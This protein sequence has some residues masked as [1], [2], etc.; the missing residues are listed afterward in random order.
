MFLLK[1]FETFFVYIRI[2]QESLFIQWYL[3]LLLELL[4]RDILRIIYHIDRMNFHKQRKFIAK[5]QRQGIAHLKQFFF[6]LL[7]CHE[8]VDILPLFFGKSDLVK[9]YV[10]YYQ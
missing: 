4:F 2:V 7:F 8:D 3:P 6:Y 1:E 10:V 9:L 5:Y